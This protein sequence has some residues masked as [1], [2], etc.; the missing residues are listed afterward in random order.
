[1]NVSNTSIQQGQMYNRYSNYNTISVETQDILE[2]FSG[3]F[4]PSKVLTTNIQEDK[5]TQTIRQQFDKALSE[6]GKSQKQLM[7]DTSTYINNA[8]SSGQSTS[9]RNNLIRMNNGA[10][11]YV[12]DKNKYLHVPSTDVLQSIQGKNGCPAS[13]TNV[14]FVTDNYT[15]VGSTL[16]TRTDIQVGTPMQMNQSCAP[17]SVNLQVLGASD[18]TFNK[19]DWLGCYKSDNTY[20]D[21]QSDLTGIV[22]ADDA[23]QQCHHRSSDIGSSTFYIDTNTDNSYSCFTSKP[24]MST[25]QIQNTMKPGYIKQV[26]G[27]IHTKSAFPYKTNYKPSAGIMNNGQI[28]IGNIT[29]GASDF[30]KYVQDVSFL[31]NVAG[32]DTCDPV[33]GAMIRTQTANYGSNCN[34]VQDTHNSSAVYNVP[35]NNWIGVVNSAI[36]GSN[37]ASSVSVPI[38][39]SPDPALGCAKVF[40]STYT[41]GSSPSVKSISIDKEASGHAAIY[42]CTNESVQ[43]NSGALAIGD[44]GNVVLTINGKILYQ[45]ETQQVGISLEEYKASNSKYGRNSLNTGEY[46]LP[47]E[48]VG[49]PSGKCAL[50]CVDDGKGNVSLK[51]LYFGLGCNP[52]G[53]TLSGASGGNGTVAIKP[54]IS[55]MYSLEYGPLSNDNKGKLVYSDDNM[56]RREYPSSMLNQGNNYINIGNYDQPSKSIRIIDNSNLDDCKTKCN[57]ISDCYGFVYYEQEGKCNLRNATDMFPM[58]TQRVLNEDAQMFLRQFKIA[59]PSTCS[60]EIVNTTGNIFNN[61]TQGTDM[62]STTLCD[63]G[64]AMNTQL[65][66]VSAKEVQLLN[67][68]QGVSQGVHTLNRKNKT[69]LNETKQSIDQMNHNS[70]AYKQTIHKMKDTTNQIDSVTAMDETTQEKMQT[71]NIQFIVWTTIASL[72]LI[73]LIKISK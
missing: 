20:F 70:L 69:L 19:A 34:G 45:S 52:P 18:P 27:V 35:P 40:A 50:M 14:D 51:I 36:Q 17:T 63:L 5:E 38:Y 2:G 46:L 72:A 33:Y 66:D 68:M 30:G 3:A 25:V 62:D 71:Q 67:A 42:D 59:N 37:S 26:S 73:L 48:F 21:M 28:A 31:A 4:G 15:Q 55:A 49:S 29:I 60:G 43:C 44:N 65:N 23:I 11:G 12:T 56:N 47:N 53:E 9:L 64:K 16:G 7:E 57:D 10:I 22:S 6:Y 1:M 8:T 32:L 24:G 58:N 13:I 54:N 61:M 39:A 41:C